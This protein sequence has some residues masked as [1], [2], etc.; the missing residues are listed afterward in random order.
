VLNVPE[1][2]IV[3]YLQKVGHHMQASA[4]IEQVSLMRAKNAM[5]LC[6][7]WRT[8]WLELRCYSSGF[9]IT[10][11]EYAGRAPMQGIIGAD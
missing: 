4:D 10:W 2:E 1:N 3:A 6:L 8:R 5:V 7:W 9:D 11:E